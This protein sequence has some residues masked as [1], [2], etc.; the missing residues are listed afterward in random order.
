M[1]GGGGG[2]GGGAVPRG[3]KVCIERVDDLFFETLCLP[4]ALLLH[5]VIGS[6]VA[7]GRLD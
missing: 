7:A 1:W 3:S 2:G 4:K 5:S 6:Q